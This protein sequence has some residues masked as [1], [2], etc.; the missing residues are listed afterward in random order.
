MECLLEIFYA[1]LCQESAMPSRYKITQRILSLFVKEP[2]W[3]IKPLAAEVKYSI[4]SVRRFLNEVGYYSSFSH[5]GSWY[6]LRSLPQFSQDGLW[7]CRDI[8][9]SRS[10]TLTQTLISLTN[11]SSAGMTAEQLGDRLHCRCHTVLV[12]LYRQGKLKRQKLGRSYIYMSV[13]PQQAKL[14]RQ[15]ISMK[16]LPV[17]P[18]PAEIIVLVLAEFIRKPESSFEQ[19]A[20]AIAHKNGAAIVTAQIEKIFE[21]HGLKKKIKT[22]RPTPCK[23]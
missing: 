6:T 22:V 13:D 5:N 3:M 8:G 1:I 21:M 9:F 17:A 23:L 4:P 7:F 14:Q 18:L 10:G 15:A 11:R 12:Q 16:S 20:K 19:L 2:C